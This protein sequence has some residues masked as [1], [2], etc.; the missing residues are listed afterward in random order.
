[1]EELDLLREELEEQ[2]RRADNRE[3]IHLGELFKKT[4]ACIEKLEE[5]ITG[6]GHDPA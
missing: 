5:R 3:Q 1:M 4:V 2:I 6:D